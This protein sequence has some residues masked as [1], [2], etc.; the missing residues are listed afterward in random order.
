[1][2]NGVMSTRT[3]TV[4]EGWRLEEIAEA[5]EGNGV[6][7]E[8]FLAAADSTDYEYDFL[9]DAPSSADLEGYLYP[10][11]YGITSADNGE[12]VVRKMLDAFGENLPPGV[13]EEAEARGLSLHDVLTL[14]SIIQREARLPEEKPVMAQVFLSR[15]RLGMRLEADPTVQYALAEEP[16]NVEEYGWWKQGL[17]LDDLAYDSPYNTYVYNGLPPGPISAPSAETILAVVQPSDT[18]YLYFV[19]KPDGSHAFAETLQ[20]HLD[21]IEQYQSG[22]E[23]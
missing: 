15:L 6:S 13:A 9:A 22:P 17:T 18:N 7:G 1:M 23:E 3:V 2:R 11:T 12:S 4:V 21:N 20:E 8:E 19:A 10:A 5:L 16:D 14:S